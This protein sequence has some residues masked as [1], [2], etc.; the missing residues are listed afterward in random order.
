MRPWPDWQFE[1]VGWRFLGRLL[2]LWSSFCMSLFRNIF[3]LVIGIKMA[4]RKTPL[5][6]QKS[7]TFGAGNGLVQTKPS[8][9]GSG[10]RM[11]ISTLVTVGV[12][13]AITW[14]PIWLAAGPG[15]DKILT[16]VLLFV[17]AAWP[18]SMVWIWFSRLQPTIADRKAR[19]SRYPGSNSAKAA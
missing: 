8:S 15:G 12:W 17:S 9:L 3:R 11:A 4:V 5:L 16:V 1:Y 13:R 10:S 14:K 6:V 2:G 7:D 19:T 18:I